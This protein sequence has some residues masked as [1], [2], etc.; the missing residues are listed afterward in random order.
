MKNSLFVRR[1]WSIIIAFSG[2][3]FMGARG[4]AAQETAGKIQGT[5]LDPNQQPV[6]GAQVFVVGSSMATQTDASGFYFINNVPPGNYSLR[7]QFIGLQPARVD[8]IRVSGG[9]TL[10]VAF[11]L[12]G[13]VALEAVSVTVAET[14]I[15]PRD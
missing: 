3:L 7:A 12:A 13:A 14:P 5:V 9:Q 15:V 10:T 2:L 1:M 11:D 4:L 6:A 8:N